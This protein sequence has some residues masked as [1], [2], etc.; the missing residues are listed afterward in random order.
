MTYSASWSVADLPA[1]DASP[2]IFLTRANLLDLLQLVAPEIAVPAPVAREIQ[3]RG[4]N[5]PAALALATV[6]W[7]QVVE[8]PFVPSAIQSWDLGQ[9]ES[10]VLSWCAARPGTDAILDDLTA[11][12]C[13]DALG[14][15]VR[16]TLGLVLLGKRRG[17]LAAA[18][19]VL[20]ALRFSG[21][22]LSNHVVDR[23]LKTVGE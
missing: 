3:H 22:Y 19:P 7:L 13:A 2:L 20:D 21:M 17:R 14:I 18:R 16:G 8:I 1:V 12:N 9:G 6:S 11:R 5:D 15:P 23:A 10:A 4:P